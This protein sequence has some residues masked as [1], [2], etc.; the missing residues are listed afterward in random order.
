MQPTL[1]QGSFETVLWD[2]VQGL[3]WSTSTVSIVSHP[4]NPPGGVPLWNGVLEPPTPVHPWCP[5][6]FSC[7]PSRGCQWASSALAPVT[8]P[9][10]DSGWTVCSFQGPL[11]HPYKRGTGLA[12]F[13]DS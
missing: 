7:S 9:G 4:H 13:L 6:V 10:L 11:L 8:P 3:S 1:L 12:H 5:L 2:F